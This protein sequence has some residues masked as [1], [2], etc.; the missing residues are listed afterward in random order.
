LIES[1]IRIHG[2]NCLVGEIVKANPEHARD[3]QPPPRV[4]KKE[5]FRTGSIRHVYHQPSVNARQYLVGVAVGMTTPIGA[6]RDLM[7]EKHARN[8]EG[9]VLAAFHRCQTSRFV[10][11]VLEVNPSDLGERVPGDDY[12]PATEIIRG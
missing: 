10:P 3:V 2:K 11:N 7:D 1:R 9:K 4:V 8:F 12:R 6:S 5:R